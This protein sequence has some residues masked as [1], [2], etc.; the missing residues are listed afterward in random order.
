MSDLQ[1]RAEKPSL[2]GWAWQELVS[3][4]TCGTVRHSSCRCQR[5]KL[6]ADAIR[7]ASTA[8][9]CA[10]GS[11]HLHVRLRRKGLTRVHST[12]SQHLLRVQS[13]PPPP[14]THTQAAQHVI[15]PA[16]PSTAGSWPLSASKR[17]Q[18][19]ST[20]TPGCRAGQHWTQLRP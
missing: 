11:T 14:H 7:A 19:G 17:A 20:V 3:Y 18:Q 8:T 13:P 12:L 9:A 1:L 10:E 5:S 15:S 2:L 6:N 4:C 16:Q